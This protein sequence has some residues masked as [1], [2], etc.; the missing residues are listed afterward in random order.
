M[1]V[2]RILVYEGDEDWIR[3][4]LSASNRA[5]LGEYK[6]PKGSIKEF[7]IQSPLPL[8]IDAPIDFIDAEKASAMIKEREF[9]AKR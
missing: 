8:S 7:Y 5:V 3:V 1:K 9:N 2:I 6:T 4:S